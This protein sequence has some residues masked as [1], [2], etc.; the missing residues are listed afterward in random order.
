MMLFLNWKMDS[1]KKVNKAPYRNVTS[2]KHKYQFVEHIPVLL[3]L[4][5]ARHHAKGEAACT[6]VIS[7]GL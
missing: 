1:A 6:S 5:H 4:L 2:Q 7:A 3:Y